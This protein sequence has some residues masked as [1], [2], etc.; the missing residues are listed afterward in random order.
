[1]SPQHCMAL[2]SLQ[3]VISWDID[4][5]NYIECYQ[6]PAASAN[7]LLLHTYE[8]LSMSD[9]RFEDACGQYGQT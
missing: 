9:D 6:R 7:R 3:D 1:M 4:E 2:C 8:V 5:E